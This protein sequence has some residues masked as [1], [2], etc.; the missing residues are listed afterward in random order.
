MTEPALADSLVH[1]GS[2]SFCPPTFLSLQACHS[3]PTTLAL[4]LTSLS[5]HLHHGTD[6]SPSQGV[7][8]LRHLPTSS[9]RTPIP[10][11]DH[12]SRLLLRS[13]ASHH[14]ARRACLECQW[15]GRRHPHSRGGL[16]PHRHADDVVTQERSA[17]NPSLDLGGIRH[18]VRHCL[19]RRGGP[20][21]A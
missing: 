4:N 15:C 11:G 1:I 9:S 12:I 14:Q 21:Q 6:A 8:I 7:Q 2:D 5:P 16:H 17:S 20:N 10:L 3:H 18:P 19:H 13:P